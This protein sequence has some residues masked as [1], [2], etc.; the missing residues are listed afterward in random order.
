MKGVKS[1]NLHYTMGVPQGS[2]LGP[3]LFSLYINDLPQQCE[4]KQ[5]QMYADDTIIF[6]QARTAE[7]TAEKLKAAME[8]NTQW[9]EQSCLSLNIGK[10]KGMFFSK[11]NVQ[12]P[13]VDIFINGEKIEIVNEFSYLGVILDSNLNM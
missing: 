8:R 7:L 1:C 3:L 2:V 6:T 5:V 11:T 13:N 4:G 10:T 12:S 9:L